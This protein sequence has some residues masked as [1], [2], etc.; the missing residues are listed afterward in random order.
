MWVHS[1]VSVICVCHMSVWV[2]ALVNVTAPFAGIKAGLVVHDGSPGVQVYGSRADSLDCRMAL[3]RAKSPSGL[4][5]I[6]QKSGN[7]W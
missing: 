1:Y 3:R 4:E 5:R 2:G 7:L 6:L